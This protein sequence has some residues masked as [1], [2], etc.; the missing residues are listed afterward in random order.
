MSRFDQIVPTDA[1]NKL[2]KLV[3]SD[4]EQ[5]E[6]RIDQIVDPRYRALCLTELEKVVL[7]INKGICHGGIAGTNDGS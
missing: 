1:Q 2:M 4:A 5:L 6:Q 7:V 3:R